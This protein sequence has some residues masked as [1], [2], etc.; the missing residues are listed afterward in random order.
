VK[1]L[2]G[3]RAFFKISGGLGEIPFNQAASV[4]I[5][6]IPSYQQSASP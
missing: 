5:S 2:P 6:I 1:L 4:A 3:T